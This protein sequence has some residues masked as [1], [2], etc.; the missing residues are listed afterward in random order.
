M[1]LVSWRVV[2][3][4]SWRQQTYEGEECLPACYLDPY[5]TGIIQEP[6][7]SLDQY[8]RYRHV[9]D[10]SSSITF[11]AWFSF[12]N[13]GQARHTNDCLV[14]IFTP[15]LDDPP[16]NP[17]L[18]YEPFLLLVRCCSTCVVRPHALVS[19]PVSLCL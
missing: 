9:Q 12:K 1:T 18:R 8:L 5:R 19:L 11:T 10:C 14:R 3:Y 4:H 15:Q 13:K 16:I 2:E 7:I 6:L 17:Y